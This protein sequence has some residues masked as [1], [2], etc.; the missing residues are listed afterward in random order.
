MWRQG[1]LRL[2]GLIV[3]AASVAQAQ[4]IQYEKYRLDNGLP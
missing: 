2:S 4:N 3:L 1:V